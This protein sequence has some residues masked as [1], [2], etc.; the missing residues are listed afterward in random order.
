MKV[1]NYIVQPEDS[2]VGVFAHEYGHDLGLP[3][4]YDTAGGGE[5][6]VD[7]WDLMSSR[8]ALAARSSSRCRPTWASG[9]SGC[10]AGPTR[11]SSNPGDG[12]ADRQARPDLAHARA[13]PRTAIRVNL[14]DK[15]VAG[16]RPAQ[17]RATCG[18]RN[19]DQDWA[20][21]NIT[22]DVWPFR[23]APT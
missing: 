6:D 2:G 21:N 5:S 22:R 13:A 17:R 14:P 16:G 11:R 7:F 20:D 18:G 23:P 4:L 10:S 3:D 12:H 9:T 19:N 15:T 1:S 8:L